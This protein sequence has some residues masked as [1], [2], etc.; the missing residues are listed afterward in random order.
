MSHK[1]M[2]ATHRVIAHDY[3]TIRHIREHPDLERV[4][5]AGEIDLCTA[6]LL[7]AA[8]ADLDARE[9]P[10]VLVDLSQVTFMALVGVH[11]L[12]EASDRRTAA[13]HRLIVAAPTHAAQRT[14]TLADAAQA[15]EIYVSGSS[16]LSALAV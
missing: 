3:L 8:L 10:N 11:V 9:V 4:R 13:G 14:L 12:R 7:R 5:P 6:P 16:A 2:P 15:L 1:I